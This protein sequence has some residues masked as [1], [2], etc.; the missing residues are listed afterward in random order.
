MRTRVRASATC[1]LASASEDC[2]APALCVGAV[3]SKDFESIFLSCYR[4]R[5]V[6]RVLS[7]H[8]RSRPPPEPL[9]PQAGW[10]CSVGL[11]DLV[12]QGLEKLLMSTLR[13]GKFCY[14]PNQVLCMRI[15]APKAPP[16]HARPWVLAHAA[17]VDVQATEAHTARSAAIRPAG[18]AQWCRRAGLVGVA[19]SAAVA[20]ARPHLLC[21]AGT[22]RM[23]SCSRFHRRSWGR[24]TSTSVT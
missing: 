17:L 11:S 9:H 13:S 4:V 12:G 10:L 23:R 24:P 7:Q 5:H 1:V 22:S 2:G 19:R 6:A 18:R 14:N 8:F 21:R 15:S 3:S 20:A 16:R